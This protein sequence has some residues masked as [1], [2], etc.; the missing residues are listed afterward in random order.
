LAGGF[1]EE[2]GGGSGRVE[3]LDAGG[4][5]DADTGGRATF[6]FFR[7]AGAFV[8]DEKGDGFA[9]VYIPGSESGGVGMGRGSERADL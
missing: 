3:G 9:P 1:V 4:H 5:G 2:D 7:E 6:D 8:A